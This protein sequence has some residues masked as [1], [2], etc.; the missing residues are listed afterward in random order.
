M[1]W[2]CV[3]AS[4]LLLVGFSLSATLA[5]V[6]RRPRPSPSL[7]DGRLRPCPQSN[8]C[9]CSE[10]SGASGTAALPF[11]G[12]ADQALALLRRVVVETGGMV[13]SAEVAH[14][15]YLYARYVTTF[16]GFVDD[17]EA[18]LDRRANTLHLRSQSRVGLADRGVN[19]RRL[20]A[21]R[22]AFAA[23]QSPG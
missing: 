1:R 19:R 9:A 7:L 10:D 13:D 14:G 2:A 21:I 6:S 15:D 22:R 8:N 4:V 23:A 18:R 11:I 12:D 17:F 3:I 5:A 16:F 20:E